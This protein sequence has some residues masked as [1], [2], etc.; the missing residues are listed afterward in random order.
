MLLN[1]SRWMQQVEL[2]HRGMSE[3]RRRVGVECDNVA[4]GLVEQPM[5]AKIKF[6]AGL[7]LEECLETLLKGG[8]LKLIIRGRSEEVTLTQDTDVK[9]IMASHDQ[10]DP[11]EWYDGCMD[12]IVVILGSLVEFGM[13]DEP[14]ME[15]VNQNNLSK[16][17]EGATVR[18]DGKLIKPPDFVKPD[19]KQLIQDFKR[20]HLKVGDQIGIKGGFMLHD[21]L[22]LTETGD[23]LVNPNWE[24]PDGII[25]IDKAEYKYKRIFNGH[26]IP[27]T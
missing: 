10:F 3:Y 14:G 6:R 11:V 7:I 21:V 23:V 20:V 12:M 13:P 16:L 24:V 26:L 18:G 17:R 9:W 5:A 8:G 25:P 15:M 19:F 4:P 22:S 1:K 27:F 2:F